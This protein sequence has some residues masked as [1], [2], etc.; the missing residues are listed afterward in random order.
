MKYVLSFLLLAAAGC[1]TQP[2]CGYPAGNRIVYKEG[3]TCEV[4]IAQVTIGS[5]LK[6]PASL[7][8]PGL[9]AFS[10]TWVEP[11]LVNGEIAFG[12]FILVQ[13]TSIGAK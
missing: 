10:L 11:G 6:I 9:S 5:D 13:R 8:G 2:K 12:H 3:K 4:R 1:A 7:K